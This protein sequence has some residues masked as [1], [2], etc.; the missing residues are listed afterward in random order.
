MKFNKFS[1]ILELMEEDEGSEELSEVE[2]KHH[3]K[4]GEKPLSHS[5]TKKTF[6]KERRAKKSFTCTQ[7]GESFTYKQNLK[8]HMNVHTG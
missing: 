2:E 1:F 6:L 3:V 4:P 5:K 7:C 8:R